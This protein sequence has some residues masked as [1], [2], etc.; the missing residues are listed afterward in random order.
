M[1]YVKTEKQKEQEYLEWKA[2]RREKLSEYQKQIG[3]GYVGNMEK[4]LE[5]WQNARKSKQ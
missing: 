3:E 5:G 1:T 2:A 4:E